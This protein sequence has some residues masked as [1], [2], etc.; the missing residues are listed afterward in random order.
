MNSTPLGKILMALALALFVGVALGYRSSTPSVP[1]TDGTYLV[2]YS[3]PSTNGFR[4]LN[5]EIHV[6][7]EIETLSTKEI[8]AVLGTNVVVLNIIN[9]KR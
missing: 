9:L 6:P 5:T 3:T 1:R 4:V 7:A 8:S 2:V